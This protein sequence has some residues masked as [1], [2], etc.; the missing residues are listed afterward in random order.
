MPQS[1]GKL[2]SCLQ[3]G[4]QRV[5]RTDSSFGSAVATTKIK[6]LREGENVAPGRKKQLGVDAAGLG[7]PS[8]VFEE[9]PRR[10]D[11]SQ[12][13]DGVLTSFKAV[14]PPSTHQEA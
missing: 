2:Y 7:H 11:C 4:D 13:E 5:S 3:P 6:R 9:E 1:H 14:P 8:V 10:L 12:A